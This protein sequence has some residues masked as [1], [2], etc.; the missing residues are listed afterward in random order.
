[1]HAGPVIHQF[2][3][4]DK[5]KQFTLPWNMRTIVIRVQAMTRQAPLYTFRWK[6]IT[7]RQKVQSLTPAP[8][9]ISSSDGS[10]IMSST[11]F[12]RLLILT[13]LHFTI[14]CFMW[15]FF[16][17]WTQTLSSF[18]II[19]SLA[20]THKHTQRDDDDDDG[21]YA[22]LLRHPLTIEIAVKLY[23]WVRFVELNRRKKVARGWCKKRRLKLM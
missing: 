6:S 17:T 13:L 5:H 7:Q 22:H 20:H 4:R 21:C 11:A 23:D 1:M 12:T 19:T 14:I 9:V 2:C 8:N 16:R 3:P 18:Y 10:A 15:I